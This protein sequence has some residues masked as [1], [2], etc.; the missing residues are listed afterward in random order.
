MIWSTP[1]L[2]FSAVPLLALGLLGAT[3]GSRADI[4]VAPTGDAVAIRAVD[5]HLG[6]LG[7]ASAFTS[8]QWLRADG[9]GRDADLLG[10]AA[11]VV[12]GSRCDRLGCVSAVPGGGAMALVTDP[13]AFA[14]DCRRAEI[15]VTPLIAPQPCAAP[16][17]IDRIALKTSGAIALHRGGE[18]WIR[19]DARTVGEDRPWSQKPVVRSVLQPRT[20]PA[21]EPD[22]RDASPVTDVKPIPVRIP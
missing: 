2:R 8:E 7:K 22:D 20:R 14:E 10:K 5:G 17:V 11:L 9:D 18:Q 16:L 4:I 6:T 3:C 13:A 21:A 1:L 19:Q 15:V 12:P